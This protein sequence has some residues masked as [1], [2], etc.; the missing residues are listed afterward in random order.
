MATAAFLIYGGLLPFDLRMPDPLHP[1][2]WLEQIQFTP[3]PHT[4][5]TDLA[6]NVA[7]GVPL[8]FF[9]MGAVRTGRGRSLRF[10]MAL[11]LVEGVS[12][13]LGTAI[14]LLQVLSPSRIGSWD[15]LLGQMLGVAFGILA[16]AVAG[17][18][19]IQWLHDLANERDSFR[20]AAALLQLYLPIY[21][22]IQLTPLQPDIAAK[23]REGRIAPLPLAYYF[24]FTF[25][26]LRNFAGNALLSVPIGALAVL[27]WVKEAATR[28]VGPAAL[29]GVSIV[30]AV[31]IAQCLVWSRY[32]G[33]TDILAGAL[34]V[35]I[36]IAAALQWARVRTRDGD[37]RSRLVHPWL[38]ITAGV[39]ILGLIADYWYPFDFQVTAEIARERLARIP[40]IPFASYYPA[41]SADPLQGLQ[42]ILRRFLL[43]VPLGLLLRVGWPGINQK[44]VG[45]FQGVITTG[46]AT[47]VLLGI[48]IGEIFLPSGY[49]DVT[50]VVLGVIGAALG[51][52]AGTA[53][54]RCQTASHLSG[55][56]QIPASPLGG[57]EGR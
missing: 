28:R 23:Y 19:V 13:T 48:A 4:S 49:P 36:G 21:L 12:M 30:I 5:R 47:I 14:E 45:R 7:I 18:T 44:R 9:L 10:G 50:E 51:A 22:I 43:A 55:S 16:W 34:G 32:A 56:Q 8:G 25:P 52:A 24:A 46:V 20:F 54:A 39:W 42:E 35:A 1:V 6:V 17:P 26:V 53:L 11:L 33:V 2:A 38:L 37:R 15:D 3:L 27:G 31:A 40:L 29:L 57:S 41:Y